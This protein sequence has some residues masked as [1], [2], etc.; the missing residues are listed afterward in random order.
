MSSNFILQWLLLIIV[1]LL[2]I[3]LADASPV[4][5]DKM[6]GV[7]LGR[8]YCI[9]HLSIAVPRYHVASD[10]PFANVSDTS[11]DVTFI[12]SAM[13]SKGTLDVVFLIKTSS[14]FTDF[15]ARCGCMVIADT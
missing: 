9:F 4:T 14:V 13:L 3:L 8:F 10:V 15:V 5:G 1:V 2:L 7:L 6:L 12:Y 11:L